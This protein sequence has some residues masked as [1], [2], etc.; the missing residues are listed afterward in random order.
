[1]DSRTSN[2]EVPLLS[3]NIKRTKRTP[4]PKLQISIPLAIHLCEP[5]INYSIYPYIAQLVGELDI[6]GGDKRK[7]GYYVGILESLYFGCQALTML[8]WSRASDYVGR[9]PILLLGL[10]GIAASMLSFGLSRTFYTL[11]LSRCFTGL[12]DGNL[13]VSKSIMGDLTDPTNCAQGFAL[14]PV[15]VAVGGVIGRASFA[16][17]RKAFTSKFWTSYPYFLP[18]VSVAGFA[19]V[20]F[21]ITL[22]FFKECSPGRRGSISNHNGGDAPVPFRELLVYPVIISITNYAVLAFLEICVTVL[23]PL[24]LA[25]PTD[26]GGMGASPAVIGYVLSSISVFNGLFQSL[27]FARL[28]RRFGERRLF[29]TVMSIYPIILLL[30]PIM[31]TMSKNDGPAWI[32]W[33]LLVFTLILTTTA[34]MGFSEFDLPFLQ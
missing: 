31:G 8:H 4:L 29:M 10:M 5:L 21:I 6:T 3:S 27:F 20:V 1:M 30:F 26:I 32:I 2:E 15:I 14:F 25:M 17:V 23:L 12:L 22:A 16:I 19:L 7:V 11:A 33:T 24:F 28:V 13:A 9:K 34:E 18:C